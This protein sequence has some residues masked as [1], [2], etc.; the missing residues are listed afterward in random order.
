MI[1]DMNYL[2]DVVDKASY[3]F[4]ACFEIRG[5]FHPGLVDFACFPL[6]ELVCKFASVLYVAQKKLRR[7]LPTTLDHFLLCAR[8]SSD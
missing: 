3:S 7:L 1:C 8:K 2:G 5:N 4:L 6:I